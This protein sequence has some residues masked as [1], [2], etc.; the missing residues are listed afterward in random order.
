MGKK[1]TTR[2][3]CEMA[4]LI[5]L[6]VVFTRVAAINVL[7]FKLGLGFLAM[8]MCGLLYGPW[9]AMGCYALADALGA[10]L[11]PTGA[12]NPAF[13]VTAAL[14]GL[15]YGLFLRG[16]RLSFRRQVLPCALVYAVGLSWG[17]NTFWI[18]LFYGGTYGARLVT[19]LPE[20]L[21]LLGV[22]LAVLPLLGLLRERL[23]KG[24]A[25]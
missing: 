21:F 8:A 11:F 5:A 4:M 18:T 15:C 24:A 17:L 9:W 2:M 25:R 14:M 13:T 1:L 23:R 10:L 22:Q 7:T 12:Y 20:C 6:E 19:R 3:L 16:E